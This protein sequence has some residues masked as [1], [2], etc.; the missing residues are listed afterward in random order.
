M[1]DT[2]TRIAAASLLLCLSTHA[3]F[4]APQWKETYDPMV[5]RTLYLELDPQDWDRVRF[6][7][8]VEGNPEGVEV[9]PAWFHAESE[10]PIQVTVRRKGATDPVLP[11]N[12]NPQKVSLKIDFNELV[13]GQTWGGVRK[14]SLEIGGGEGP[15]HEGFAWQIHR[16]A[17]DAGL[18]HYDAAN[19]AWVK[20]H[21]NGIYR[22]VYTSTEQRDEQF[23][24][25]RDLYGP[26]NTWLY[27]VDGSTSLEFGPGPSPTF[28]HLNFAPF[29]ERNGAA[30]PDF[31]IDLPQWIDMESLMALAACEAF[32]ENNDGLVTH[33]GKNSF[34]ADFNPPNQRR[35]MY[36]PWDMDSSIKNGTTQIYGNDAYQTALLNHPWF[37]RVY[38]HTLRELLAGPL[39]TASL[40]AFLDRLEPVLGPALDSD[41]FVAPSSSAAGAFD[42]LRS[43]VGVRNASV[44]SKLLK[45]HVPRPLLSHTG[46]EVVS[47]YGLTMTAP[48]GQIYYTL[49]GTDP[50]APGD[51]PAAGAVPYSAPVLIDRTTRITARTLLSGNW[52]GLPAKATFNITNYATPLRVTEIMYHPAD[53]DP[54][55]SIDRDAYE[56]I[57]L[58][59]TWSEPLNIADFYFD[60]ISYTFPPNTV[61]PPDG[62][63]VL[64]RN[65]AAFSARYPG[66][67]IDGV[68]LGGLNNGGEKIRLRNT[69]GTAVISVEYDDDPPWVLS[70][71]G[72]GWSLVNRN[73]GG[74]PDD[75]ENWRASSDRHGSPG[76][77]DPVPVIPTSL[78][79]SEI[80]ANTAPPYEDAIELSNDGIPADV[81][82]WYLSDASRDAAGELDPAVLKKF[83]LPPGTNLAAGHVVVYEQSFNASN[84]LVPFSL[85]FAGGRVYL[86]SANPAGDLTGFITA[87]E[88]PATEL[89]TAWG[90]G[91][92]SGGEPTRLAAPTFGV[93]SPTSVADFRTGTGA[94]NGG[95]LTGPV[96]I[97]EIMYNPLPADSEFVEVHNISGAPVDISA[98]DIEGVGTFEFPAGTHL[99][100]GGYAVIV[101]AATTTAE[102]FRA[103]FGVPAESPVFSHP[104]DLGNAGEALALEKP[105][106]VALAPDIRMDR[107]RYNDKPPWPTEAGGTGPSLERAPVNG[108]GNNPFNWRANAMRGTPGR[109][110]VGHGGIAISRG[111]FWDYKATPAALDIRWTWGD[112]NDSA[113][114]K[115]QA[116]AGY[117]EPFIAGVVPYG[118]NPLQKYPTT[119]FRKRFTVPENPNQVLALILSVFYDD[120]IVV[121][122][123]DT[124][125]ARRGLP[126]GP[127]S[128]AS[129][130]TSD[131]EA[132]SYEQIDLRFYT[133]Y[134]FMGEN[135]LA[136]E[137][138]QS[139]PDSADLVW[140]AELIYVTNPDSDGDGMPDVWES[141][142]GLDPADAADAL[143]D[144]D[145]DGA[146]NAAE[147]RAGTL[148]GDP[149]SC[150]RIVPAG[151][152]P[153][154]NQILRWDSIPGHIYHV[155]YSPDLTTWFS[156]GD[157]GDVTATGNSTAF[158]DP[159]P[160]PVRRFYKVEP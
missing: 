147:F 54:A 22:G 159:A 90:P 141:A 92:G 38:E 6:D 35:R 28:T 78:V 48:A 47:G 121:Y 83:R 118:P 55:D 68:Y 96:V 101:D 119:Y 29:K 104:F 154:G 46:G 52:S 106:P 10:A 74:H 41:P 123:N 148:P 26:D 156:F 69:E 155:S 135:V 152:S 51:A 131:T 81:S 13:P 62:F 34:A 151:F 25:N 89:N 60:G 4:A 79:I 103:A 42:G 61:V 2:R 122:L 132:V 88:F 73:P 145:H 137:V 50:R 15:L 39:S 71:D 117:G 113:W 105:N 142:Y 5:V 160:P 150:F 153:A 94:G 93:N 70:P 97:S 114:L 33:S 18:Y 82:G 95:I 63:I 84:P 14:L 76:G 75:P 109:P 157:S 19:A 100:S 8:P 32:V 40:H 143:E 7:E 124:E 126:S 158:I 102:A 128:Y 130:A 64:V 120:G 146:T 149:A 86:S 99:P 66:V 45:P 116:P 1:T 77:P 129:H 56:F 43:W 107:V 115:T 133:Q 80:L 49:D 110:G 37:G 139:A 17:A 87:L 27:K 36:F 112:Y 57:E 136:V 127:I 144:M 65:Q 12:G 20:L 108:Y 9:A 3:A 72:M 23:L 58:Q 11:D 21:V 111:S 30:P 67:A 125:I 140:D 24:R 98:W 44:A 59:N 53:A 138:H 16:L 91:A 31:D 85:N 134:L